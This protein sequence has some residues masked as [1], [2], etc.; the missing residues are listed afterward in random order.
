MWSY[1]LQ[2]ASVFRRSLQTY[3]E[4]SHKVCDEMDDLPNGV[5]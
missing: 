5:L 1:G 2:E 3:L 4:V